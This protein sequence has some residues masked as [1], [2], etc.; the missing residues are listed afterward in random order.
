[1]K[2]AMVVHGAEGRREIKIRTVFNILGPLSNPASAK[3]QL[4]GVFHPDLTS[5]MCRVLRN[6][7]V[8]HAMVVHGAEGL[9][10]ISITH[11]TKITELKNDSITSYVVTPEMFHLQTGSHAQIMGGSA[12]TNAHILKQILSG[13]EHSCRSD[14]VIFNTAAVL[15]LGKKAEKFKDGIEI[16]REVLY[17]GKAL[18]K[19]KNFVDYTRSL[20][21]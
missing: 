4:I 1:V 20:K 17:S 19:M 6:L 8:K 5:L 9:D 10:E 16:A 14:I 13:K 2:H 7:G 18:E 15:M 21:K 11:R 3:A 12:S